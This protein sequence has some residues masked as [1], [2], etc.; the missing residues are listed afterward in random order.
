M[1]FETSSDTSSTSLFFVKTLFTRYTDVFFH[2]TASIKQQFHQKVNFVVNR[3][4]SDSTLHRNPPAIFCSFQQ[5]VPPVPMGSEVP[6]INAGFTIPVEL[7]NRFFSVLIITEFCNVS[8]HN[9]PQEKRLRTL[10]TPQQIH[11]RTF[12][13]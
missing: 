13:L 3:T 12:D 5:S 10:E 2:P 4:N 9:I 7:L 11:H 1:K 8:T 6:G